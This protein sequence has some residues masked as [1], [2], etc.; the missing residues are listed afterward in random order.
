MLNI[1]Y[2]KA[3]LLAE[4]RSPID[5]SSPFSGIAKSER[6]L[7]LYFLLIQKHEKLQYKINC[8]SHVGRPISYLRIKH[9][10]CTLHSIWI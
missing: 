2:F 4:N 6:K 9:N 7:M 5:I 1:Q 10:Q 8:Q 3:V